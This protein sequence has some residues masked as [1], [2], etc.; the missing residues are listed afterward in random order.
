MRQIP[1]L[2]RNRRRQRAGLV[3]YWN[4]GMMRALNPGFLGLTHYSNRPCLLFFFAQKDSQDSVGLVVG[5]DSDPR[6]H[7]SYSGLSDCLLIAYDEYPRGEPNRSDLI[8][9]SIARHT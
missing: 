4:A 7:Q 6:C 3:E 1:G 2:R 8:V 9:L 5:N